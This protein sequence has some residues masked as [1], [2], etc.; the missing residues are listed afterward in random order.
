LCPGLKVQPEAALAHAKSLSRLADAWLSDGASLFEVYQGRRSLW[1]RGSPRAGTRSEVRARVP[2][3]G[4]EGLELRVW[5]VGGQAIQRRLDAEADL[6]GEIL[7]AEDELQRITSELGDRDRQLLAVLRLARATRRHLTLVEVLNDLVG[8]VRRMTV[9]ELAF[10]IV[11][12]LGQDRLVWDPA[13]PDE[14]RDFIRRVSILTRSSGP[15]VLDAEVDGVTELELPHSV[16]N[17][18]AVPIEMVGRPTAVLGVANQRD[19]RISARTLKLLQTVAE[20][21][22]GLI[23]SAALHDRALARGRSQRETELAADIQSALMPHAAP[24]VP[25]VDLVARF[26]SAAEVGGD[27]YDYVVRRNGQLALF[28]GDVSGK[29]WPAAMVMTMTLAVLR[30]ASQLVERPSDVLERANVELHTHLSQIDAF[31]TAF[32]GFYDGGGRRLAFAS[33]GHSPVLYRARG[34]RTRLLRATGLPL[35][36]LLGPAPTAGVVRLGPGDLLVVATDGFSEAT[37]PAGELFGYER[38]QS[39]VESIAA[40]PAAEVADHLFTAVT[41]F[42]AGRPQGDD[43]TL[44]VMKGK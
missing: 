6:L 2:L 9:A 3:R 32:A 17:L 27:F 12:E 11:S 18:I 30:G 10:T 36:I 42:G 29:G 23:E 24:E 28:V 38:L 14:W 1:R 34:G 5:G 43:Q 22:G 31:V 39:L 13:P 40:E 35:G 33:A 41:E 7:R 16:D 20:L 8:E 26:R 4:A 15:L 19:A 37:S 44:L 25:G 21:A